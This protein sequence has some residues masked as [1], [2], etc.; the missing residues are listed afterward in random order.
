MS[1]A[2]M[3]AIAFAGD[4]TG[5]ETNSLHGSSHLSLPGDGQARYTVVLKDS[6]LASYQGE[7]IKLRSGSRTFDV[8][9]RT[10]RGRIDVTS[11]AANSYVSMLQQKQQDFVNSISAQLARQIDPEMQFQHAINAVVLD[12]TEAEAE[13]LRQRDD[14][15]MLDREHFEELLTDRGPSFI[16]AD[17]IWNGFATGGAMSKGEGVVI[18]EL[19]T[20]IAWDSPSFAG[21]G[22]IDGYVHVNPLGS[23]NF[24]GT[25]K[26][27]GVD[28]GRCNNKLVGMYS[29]VTG[30]T[31]AADDEGH[32]S[33]TASTVAGN[34][35]PAS[36]I[37][38]TFTISGV[39]PHA[40]VI[41]YKVCAAGNGATCAST[42]S[43]SAANQAVADGIV[44]AINFSIGG[45]TDPW[46]DATS[47]AFLGAV[48]AGIFV[49][50]AG[51][52]DG[53]VASS[54]SH[55][56][57]WTVTA[58]ASSEDRVIG[59]P[60]NL[61]G[62]GSPPANTQN[63]ALRPASAPLPTADLVNV[64]LIQSP[65][66]ADGSNDG[67]AAYPAGTFLQGAT[68]AIAVLN[69]NQNASNCG[70]GVRKTN[71]TNAG[72]IGVIYVDPAYINLGASGNAW[73]M[74]LSDWNNVYTQIQTNPA[75]ATASISAT[76]GKFPGTGDVI[77]DFSSRG[78]NVG[79]GGQLIVKPEISAPGVD[80]LA[81]YASKTSAS[82]STPN[83]PQDA[84]RVLLEN[85]TSMATPH[86]AGSGLL[87][88][89]LHPTWTPVQIRSALMLNARLTGLVK[90]DNS[91]SDIFD[92]GSGRV[93]LAAA[94]QTG[95]VMDETYANFTAANPATGGKIATLNLPS[96]AEGNCVSS[97]AFARTM[98][99]AIAHGKPAVK[100]TLAVSGMPSG[101][102]TVSPAS[103]TVT[104]NG[105][106]SFTVTV[107]ATKLPDGAI[108][109]G[110]L[111]LTPSDATIPTEH[112]PIA[113]KK[114][115]PAITVAP[116]SLAATQM[117]N[118]TSTQTIA[119][120]NVGNPTLNW[121]LFTA[122]QNKTVIPLN[123]TPATSGYQAGYYTGVT[124]GPGYYDAENFDLADQ[125]TI[126]AIKAN[127]FALPSGGLTTANTTQIT[128]SVYADA[129]NKPAGAP[130]FTTGALAT[131]P[132]WTYSSV[133]TGPAITFTGGGS[134]FGVD[135]TASGVPPLALPAGR[136]WL[137]AF[138][139]IIGTG[140]QTAANPLWAW[141][142]NNTA[143]QVGN[144][145]VAVRSNGTAWTT[146]TT[147]GV[148][149]LSAYIAGTAPCKMPAWAS[150]TPNPTSGSLGYNVQSTVTV[151]F[152]STGLAAGT[153]IGEA[154]FASN[155]PATPQAVVALSLTVSGSPTAS[156][157]NATPASVSTN[158]TTLL[159]VQVAPG[160]NPVSTGVQVRA[161]LSSIGG[162]AS[163]P[164]VDDGTNGD[165]TAGDGIYSYAAT[166][167]GS[168]V[169]GSKTLPISV[170]DAQGRSTSAGIALSVGQQTALGASASATPSTVLAGAATHLV[171]TV[172]P[173]TNPA[174]TGTQVKADLSSIGGSAS[175]AFVDDGSGASF[176]FD[177]TVNAA[178]SSGAKLL[179]VTVT[180]AQSRSASA[181]I[182]LAVPSKTSQP[183]SGSGVAAPASLHAGDATTLIVVV[184]PATSPASTGIT[185]ATNLSAIGGSTTQPLYDDGT[186]GDAVAGDGVY[187]LA[188]NIGAGTSVGS[189]TLPVSIADAQTRTASISIGLSIAASATGMSASGGSANPSTLD[190]GSSTVLTA[191]IAPGTNP[192]STGVSASADLS[193][194]GGSA[195][196]QFYDDGTHGDATA[197]D[198]VYSY[199]TTIAPG[200]APGSKA[201]TVTASDAQSRTSS[202]GIGLTV[203]TPTAPA[204]SNATASP[205]VVP[206]GA[207]THLS[208]QVAGGTHP[209][210]SSIAVVADLTSIGGDG[211]QAFA[212]QG[213]GTFAFDATLD[214]GTSP[215]V[216]LLA[217]TISDGE[218]RTAAA[219]IGLSVP[220]PGSPAG[221]GIASPASVVPGN[222]ALLIVAVT[223]GSNPASTGLTVS[224]DLS[225]IGGSATQQFYDDGTNGD[226][227]AGDGLFSFEA[228]VDAATPINASLNLPA[229]ITDDQSRSGSAMILLKTLSDR[230]FFD[231]FDGP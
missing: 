78:P 15:L 40:N 135:L 132:L 158:G 56:E 87:L 148:N 92:R 156:N 105:S 203:A 51:G 201:I 47:L 188:T 216:K 145:P 189:K 133:L 61:T 112:M 119:I 84:T 172:T 111:T 34:Q 39:A 185:V 53:P 115:A 128:F 180:D 118:T 74:L 223:P 131:A 127:G 44:D 20:G 89:S 181:A 221:A 152:D 136:Y 48:N 82:A 187:S 126:T 17:Q 159:T 160:A 175:Q 162:S 32:G 212:D 192:A 225:S 50:T 186:H 208:V 46:N 205:A 71:A 107:D 3:V 18:G 123:I 228:T 54:I 165:A 176:S 231:G 79:I 217:V 108:S 230:L 154:C 193:S 137:V 209:S 19:D 67:C 91:P 151:K 149:H 30:V 109:Q 97:C 70:S 45:G 57:P 49:A 174:S 85:G 12:L 129:S 93:D 220:T 177:A 117:P 42:A 146:V 143:A 75:A 218:G 157:A 139:T 73:S 147:S 68:P 90:A 77:A 211:S 2:R 226:E 23:G 173:G 214:A 6:P 164:M 80:I 37:G 182:G 66:F 170:T 27:G 94:A 125:T 219:T 102:T 222:S 13:Q 153:Y 5:Q 191:T 198:G 58:A 134:V 83:L 29:Y 8:A 213:D 59:F 52:N 229:T 215:G 167:P 161:N 121:S 141:F 142:Y 33:H 24:L 35:R 138:P 190:I 184:T 7:P 110:L 72:A 120:K 99:S 171:V 114:A 86:I 113:V 76:G 144:R 196:Q 1:A 101:S 21:T 155:D 43:T 179:S 81:A 116:T 130:G 207:T 183:L 195:S 31:S 88:R 95:L 122:G 36:Y 22:P 166:I 200:T 150:Y 98:R 224:V 28:A 9:P 106:A 10:A 14:V 69:L 100:W 202:T 65:T 38:G 178:T 62:P 25:C 168:V 96:M 210:S 163:Q 104:S 103:F 16:G 55:I 197:G 64:P 41:A 199:Q 140:A 169:S 206:A 63:L 26:T 11:A 227:T 204:A 124:T 60:F 194:I 4:Y